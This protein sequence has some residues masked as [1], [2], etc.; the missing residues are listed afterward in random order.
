MRGELNGLMEQLRET[1]EE[2]GKL[3]QEGIFKE[4]L[5]EQKEGLTKQM[6][7][8][9]EQVSDQLSSAEL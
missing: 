9:A 2:N 1:E 3:R 4:Q 8:Q 7:E 5:I 6:R